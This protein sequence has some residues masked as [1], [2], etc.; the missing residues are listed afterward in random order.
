M[1]ALVPAAL[2]RDPR[3]RGHQAVLHDLGPPRSR[4]VRLVDPQ[5]LERNLVTVEKHGY[6]FVP[7]TPTYLSATQCS[8]PTDVENAEDR[9]GGSPERSCSTQPVSP[10]RGE[11]EGFASPL[12]PPV[13]RGRLQDFK[14]HWSR[15][16]LSATN[17]VPGGT[18]Y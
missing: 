17:T 16:V 12:P 4:P 10:H 6:F 1:L 9:Q 11:F 5:L 15:E 14:P 3:G 2:F 7:R 13:L 8:P 18:A